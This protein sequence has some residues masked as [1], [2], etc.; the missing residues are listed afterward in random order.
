MIPSMNYRWMVW[1]GFLYY[2]MAGFST[3]VN[4]D[5]LVLYLRKKSVMPGGSNWLHLT[6]RFIHVYPQMTAW[7]RP[8][9]HLLADWKVRSL[10]SV[11]EPAIG[12]ALS[13]FRRKIPCLPLFKAGY[14]PTATM[15]IRLQTRNHMNIRAIWEHYGWYCTAMNFLESGPQ[16][17]PSQGALFNCR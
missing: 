17:N 16:I 2:K 12:G 9:G 7:C 15:T 3:T 8:W 13:V 1:Y 4:M 11:P 5:D 10:G 6:V 14:S